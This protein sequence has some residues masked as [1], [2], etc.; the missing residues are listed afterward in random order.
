V[1]ISCVS[2][3][4]IISYYSSYEEAPNN[5]PIHG[6]F[7]LDAPIKGVVSFDKFVQPDKISAS[8]VE[9]S[10]AMVKVSI[11]AQSLKAAR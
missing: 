11:V 6:D 7:D 10:W 2:F 5:S 9:A 1:R 8:M 4:G 3:S